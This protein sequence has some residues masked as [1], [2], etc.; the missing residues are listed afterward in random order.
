VD[1]VRPPENGGER[2]TLAGVLG[3][4]R[5][6]V[7]NKVVEC[8][9]SQRAIDGSGLDGPARGAGV[10]FNLR[11]AIVHLIEETGRHCGH[12]DLLP[13]RDEF[14]LDLRAGGQEEEDRE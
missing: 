9:R 3:F 10:S 4:L 11:Y 5:A 8:A 6:T 2:E 1:R 14:D 7:V 12:L 13:V